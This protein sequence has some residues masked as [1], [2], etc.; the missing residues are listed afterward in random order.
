ERFLDLEGATDAATK[1]A[2]LLVKNEWKPLNNL[3]APGVGIIS[4]N[5]AKRHV[6]NWD[7][8]ANFGADAAAHVAKLGE[9]T[10]TQPRHGGC[11]RFTAKEY[12]LEAEWQ[13]GQRIGRSQ[14]ER[15]IE[16]CSGDQTIV[17]GD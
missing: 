6:E 9:E 17:A 1:D 7:L 3:I 10:L 11:L 12:L 5:N 4:I 14:A 15:F 16:F 2:V 13:S 8:R